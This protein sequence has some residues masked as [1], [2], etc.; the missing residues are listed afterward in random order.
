MGKE[1]PIGIFDSGVGG[2]TVVKS[3]LELLPGESFIYFGDTANVPYGSKT[4]EQLMSYATNIL[5]FLGAKG[6]KAVVVACGTHSSLTLPELQGQYPFPMLGVVKAGSSSA[7]Q[8]SKN[9]RI[10]VLAT[11][12][13]VNSR[14]YTRAIQAINP[15]CLVF[16]RACQRFVPLIESGVLSGEEIN[17]AVREYVAPLLDDKIDSLVLGCTHYPFL[18]QPIKE[19]VGPK[20]ELVDPSL[21]TIAE[22]REMLIMDDLLNHSGQEPLREFYVSGHDE[23]FFKVGRFLLGDM[24]REVKRLHK[25]S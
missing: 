21:G 3:L 23:S 20:V 8:M 5:N 18:S 25:S 24:V 6:V 19:F 2:L 14:A 11:Q 10:G 7:I 22:L 9:Y 1:S 15:E 17:Q 16:E 4:Q 13:T 12:A